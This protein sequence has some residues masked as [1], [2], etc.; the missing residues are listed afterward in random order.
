MGDG[1][2]RDRDI[3]E[4]ED[5]GEP[6]PA[7]DGGGVLDRFFDLLEIGCRFGAA[8]RG[9]SA[10]APVG[11]VSSGVSTLPRS[12]LSSASSWLALLADARSIHLPIQKR[13]KISPK[14]SSTST[15]PVSL[16]SEKTAN[17]KSSAS[18]SAGALGLS[19]I[20]ASASA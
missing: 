1:A 3:G 18:N 7:A 15:A 8:G 9:V 10:G 2:R 19:R 4:D 17:R 13:A 11:G 14:I 6:Q 20:R 16:C 12:F 5:I